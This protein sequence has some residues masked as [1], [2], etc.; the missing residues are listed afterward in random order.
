MLIIYF[1][2]IEKKLT[3]NNNI[4]LFIYDF[5]ISLLN[6]A[7]LVEELGDQFAA[8]LIGYKGLCIV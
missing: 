2:K 3:G 5:Y 7:E 1:D 4:Y 6:V 8:V